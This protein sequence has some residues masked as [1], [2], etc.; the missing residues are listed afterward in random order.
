MQAQV[1]IIIICYNAVNYTKTTIESL[2]KTTDIPFCMTIIDNGSSDSTW[3]YL[4]S[5]KS[6]GF[7]QKIY[8]IKNQENMGVGFA[9][10]QGLQVSLDNNY[11]FSCFCNNDLYFSQN[12]L[13]KML[14]CIKQNPNVVALNPLRTAV[15]TKYDSKI[16]TMDKLRSLEET[17]DWRKELEMFSEMPVE[18]FDVFAQKIVQQNSSE[19]EIIKFPDSLST[20][21]CLCRTKIY[22]EL[23]YFA[24]PSFPKYGGEDIDMC[25]TVMSKGYDC[26]ICHDTYVHHFRGKSIKSMNRQ[27]LLK[28]SNQILYKKWQKEI[29]SFC[30][31]NPDI[32]NTLYTTN[33]TKYWLLRELDSDIGFSKGVQN[34]R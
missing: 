24:D 8:L 22:K 28:I 33:A 17:E 20:C 18:Q 1:N 27:Q 29:L 26:A 11:E 13:T 30:R 34:A 10:N 5:I 9:Y 16:S 23:G 32:L 19:L 25:W 7:L 21:I 12:W 2:L 14:N 3:D 15:R 4:N 6:D 31:S